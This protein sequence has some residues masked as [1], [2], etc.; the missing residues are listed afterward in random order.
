MAS[1]ALLPFSPMISFTD[2]DIS[3]W[4]ASRPN[5]KPA[6]AITSTIK[7]PMENIE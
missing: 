2:L 4:S 5:T 1:I 3:A 6:T 7:G